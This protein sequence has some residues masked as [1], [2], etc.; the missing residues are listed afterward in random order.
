M[1]TPHLS[2]LPL[3]CY[4]CGDT[5]PNNRIHLQ[6]KHFCC[7]GCKTVYQVLSDN[8]M[9]TYYDLESHPGISFPTAPDQAQYAWLNNEEVAQQL[10]DFQDNHQHRV[11]FF[12]PQ[13]HCSSCVWL[14]ENLYKLR[15][16][17][18]ASRVDFLKKQISLSFDPQLTSLQEVANLLATLGYAPDIRLHDGGGSRSSSN[19]KGF[20][21]QLGIAGFAYG[22]IMLLSFPEYL[23]LDYIRE[24]QFASFFGILSLLL[25]LPVILYSA[26]RFYRSAWIGLKE[27]HLNIDVPITLGIFVLFGRSAWEILTHSGPG[28]MD[29]LAGLVFLLLAGKWFQHKT[30]DALSFD[31]DFT[32]YFP[33]TSVRTTAKG[34]ESVLVTT[35][36]PGDTIIVKNQELIPADG[37]L[38]RGAAKIDYS[39]VTGESELL[40]KESG[41]LL[42]AGGRQ[43]GEALEMTLTKAVS[44]SYLTQLWNDEVFQKDQTSRLR[45]LTDR[46]A[47]YFTGLVLLIALMA[48][49]YWWW[50]AGIG[51]A[52]NVFSAVLIVA[53][54]CALALAIPVT[55][56]NAMRIMG[57]QG[58]YLKNT[59]VIE[60]MARI[61]HIVWDKTGTLT[62]KG[63]AGQLQEL[64]KATSTEK[65]LLAA[66]ASHSSHP[67]SRAVAQAWKTTIAHEVTQFEEVVGMGISGIVAGH[68]LLIGKRE[69]AAPSAT[70]DEPPTSGTWMTIDGRPV[71]IVRLK[72]GFRAGL[73][74]L[75]DRLSHVYHQAMIS[76]D[77]ATDR[78][79][80][81]QLFPNGTDI[82][83]EQTPED[84][85]HYIRDQ[86]SRGAVVLMVGDGLND[87]GALKQSDVGVAIA[88][89]VNTF[90]P[91]CDVILDAD[92][93]ER[94]DSY[95]AF[96]RRSMRWVKRGLF[97]SLSYNLVGLTVAVQGWLTPLIAAIL[98]PV[99]SVSVVIVGLLSTTLIGW[100]LQKRP[101]TQS[102]STSLSGPTEIAPK[103][104]AIIPSMSESRHLSDFAQG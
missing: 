75:I 49:G 15:P 60:R 29:S 39:F 20:Y 82:R 77:A 1:S 46:S 66:L 18:L 63:G 81:R 37:V 98:M 94:I 11:R 4:H 19:D 30:Y 80:L 26:A 42:Y 73:Q 57:R 45:S 54:P 5:C 12:L 52:V 85:L 17:I 76:G 92:Q 9:C 13:I 70:G 71:A 95:L 74:G 91:A 84:K 53:C 27:R 51:M 99:S 103:E 32:A 50:A 3:H 55:L 10:L 100:R 35:L 7:E 61:S 69:Y 68:H 33:L 31:R 86:Q 89:D 101:S 87:A 62:H 47:R 8:D 43:V 38:T 59:Q 23:G 64:T 65:A 102:L 90:T 58:V 36:A 40:P 16:G 79:I 21:L 41:D 78:K 56:G 22:N 2:D 97:L 28:Y 25:I 67:V 88:E 104:G 96:S 48:G 93:L 24:S 44:Q 83:F 14:L 72:P 34:E 6:E